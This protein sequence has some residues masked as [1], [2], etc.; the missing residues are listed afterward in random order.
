MPK[1]SVILPVYNGATYLRDSIESVLKQD[2][3]DLE[4]IIIDDCSF[5][6]SSEI[7]KIYVNADPRV[8]YFRNERNLKLPACLNLGFSKAGGTYWTWTSCDN[9]Y[10]KNAFTVMVE[11]LESDPYVGLV[12]ADREAIDDIGKVIGYI[13]AGTPD[14]LIIENVVGACFLYKKEVALKVGL[15][16]LNCF[17]CEDYEY[18]LRIGLSAKLKRINKCL[19]KYRYHKNSLS[20]NNKKTVIAMGINIQ[21]KYKNFYINTS[22]KQAQFYAFLRSRD[23]YNPWRQFYLIYVLFYNPIYFFKEIKFLIVS[24]I[25]S[26]I[27]LRI[28][29]YI[30][31]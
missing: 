25:Y 12:Y 27:A 20:H 13:S 31:K 5:D 29:S 4:L 23:V 14:D 3:L 17:L 9:L 19:Y 6:N 22:D 28:K 8:I 11:E 24:R 30:F 21:K 15:Y 26:K 1:I 16:N 18:W 10:Y 7:A 2:Y